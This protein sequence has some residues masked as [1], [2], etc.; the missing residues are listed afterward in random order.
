MEDLIL[1]DIVVN[2]SINDYSE[3]DG[4]TKYGSNFDTKSKD[5]SKDSTEKKEYNYINFPA[6]LISIYILIIVLAWF[7]VFNSLFHL[8]LSYTNTIQY[9]GTYVWIKIIYAIIITAI[10]ILLTW[11]TLKYR[12]YLPY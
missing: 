1:G 9:K 6:I 12:K 4:N 10:A 7:D 2:N 11:L 8:T 3:P 5:N